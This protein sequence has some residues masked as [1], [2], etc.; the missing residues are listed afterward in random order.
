VKDFLDALWA[1]IKTEP[2]VLLSLLGAAFAVAASFG[3][4][5][6]KEQTGAITGFVVILLGVIT[7]Q[8]VTPNSK[9]AAEDVGEPD[10]P[11]LVAGDA[12]EVI[13]G[14]PVDVV[15][16]TDPRAYADEALGD[17]PPR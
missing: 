11:E 8:S 1:R 6:S 7:R 17:E 9:V 5:L 3:L 4:S 14:A 10:Q 16:T 13:T 2:A 12:S 15:P